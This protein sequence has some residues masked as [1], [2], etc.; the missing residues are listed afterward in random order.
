MRF[1][2]KDYDNRII[3]NSG[4]IP[5]D[6]PVFFLRGRDKLAPKLLLKWASEL[7]LNGGDLLVAQSAIKHAHL[8]IKYQRT[9]GSKLADHDFTPEFDHDR[10][11]ELDKLVVDIDS[12][13]DKNSDQ[14]TINDKIDPIIFTKIESL[15]KLVPDNDNDVVIIGESMLKD[16]SITKKLSELTLSDFELGNVVLSR[17]DRKSVV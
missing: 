7:L 5:E 4:R 2:R 12:Y 6:E 3:D 10:Q 15:L 8:M 1:G 14:L 17:A 11:T 13:S 16:G 9:H